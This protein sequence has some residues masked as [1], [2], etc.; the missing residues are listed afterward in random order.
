MVSSIIQC[1]SDSY[2]NIRRFFSF[3]FQKSN[4]WISFVFNNPSLWKG[5]FMKKKIAIVS[6][7]LFLVGGAVMANSLKINLNGFHFVAP[8]VNGKSNVYQ[9]QAGEIIYDSGDANFW[10]Y[11]QADTWVNLSGGANSAVPAGSMLPYAG[12]SA[13]DG[14]LIADG[15]SLER[16]EYPNLYAAIGTTYG[17]VDLDHFN[18]PDT[19]NV[20]LRGVNASSRTISSI[21]YPSVTLGS[22][23]TDMLQGHQHYT[24]DGQFGTSAGGGGGGGV[25]VTASGGSKTSTPISDGTHGTPRVGSETAPV[26]MGVNY[27]I[28]Y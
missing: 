28:K 6:L 19:R 16:A 15:S 24:Y 20:F 12:A 27:I 26:N 25:F 13:P 17:A 8:A 21:T 18:L 11:D 9:P 4:E 2:Q 14:Y 1:N 10:G 3:D 22:T 7:A 5:I 23:T